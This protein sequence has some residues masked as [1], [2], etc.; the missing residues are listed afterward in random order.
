MLTTIQQFITI[1]PPTIGPIIQRVDQ[2][3]E[4]TIHRTNGLQDGFN[5]VF[6]S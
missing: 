2:P 4:T 3:F 5:S 1:N 6:I